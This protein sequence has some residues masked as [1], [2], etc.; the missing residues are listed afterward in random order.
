[1]NTRPIGAVRALLLTAAVACSSSTSPGDGADVAV[2]KIDGQLREFHPNTESVSA[3]VDGESFWLGAGNDAEGIH[4]YLL[5]SGYNG[6]AT[7]QL[8]TES[9]HAELF[10][11]GDG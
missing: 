3:A 5:L 11:G 7:Y 9:G 1:M 8:G 2:F 10:V 6:P 4:L